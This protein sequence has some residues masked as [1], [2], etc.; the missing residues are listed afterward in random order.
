MM[1]RKVE[2][3][4]EQNEG[5]VARLNQQNQVYRYVRGVYVQTTIPVPKITHSSGHSSGLDFED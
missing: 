2:A 4:E 1:G 3:L 5:N